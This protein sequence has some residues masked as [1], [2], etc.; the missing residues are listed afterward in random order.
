MTDTTAEAP[1]SDEDRGLTARWR[2]FYSRL[3]AAVQLIG[4]Q[5]WLPVFF[6]IMFC[7]CYIAAFHAPDIHDAPVGLSAARYQQVEGQLVAATKGAVDLKRYDN[8]DDAIAAVRDGT[9]VGALVYPD[10]PGDPVRLYVASAHQFQAV[11]VIRSVFTP[12]FAAQDIAL[13]ENDLAPLPDRDTFGMTP[14]Y[15][16]LCWCIG[17]YMVAMFI[18]MMG[19]PLLHR[20]R[21]GIILGGAAV[22]SLLANF[23][24]GPVIGAVAGH[25]WQLVLIAFGW[26]VAIGLTVNGLSYFVGRFVA[27]PAILIF[28][29]LSVP[30]SGAAFPTWM[31]PPAFHALHPYVVGFGMTEMIK[32]TL[33][34]VGEPHL[35]G[36]RLMLGYI[37]VGLVLMAIGKPWRER[38]EV[39]RIL[40]GRTTMVADAQAAARDHGIA[41]REKVLAK[42][43]VVD[44]DAAAATQLEDEAEQAGDLFVN[45]GR[46]LS[47]IGE[48]PDKPPRKA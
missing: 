11:Q 20:T 48:D 30:A 32:R 28:V 19:A 7:F 36:L 43:G 33:Y 27:L 39:R 5:L 21:V 35:V 22:L 29:F 18:G 9:M 16:M 41:E 4:L 42:Y 2:R 37:A 44:D 24:A 26:I 1:P 46:S 40:A 8:P 12:I 17:G 13:E 14:M 23:I 3:P 31:L 6:I 34:G 10:T 38:R 15:L 45:Y 47:G 25:F